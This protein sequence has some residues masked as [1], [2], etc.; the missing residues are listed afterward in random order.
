MS[1]PAEARDGLSRVWLEILR[2][3]HPGMGWVLVAGEEPEPS[4][5][6]TAEDGPVGV[7][8]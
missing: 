3:R 5:P 8:A 4:Q 7:A 1:L 6:L 2:E